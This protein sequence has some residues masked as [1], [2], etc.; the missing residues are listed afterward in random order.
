MIKSYYLGERT[1]KAEEILEIIKTKGKEKGYTTLPIQE[2]FYIDMVDLLNSDKNVSKLTCI[3]ARCGIGKSVLISAYTKWHADNNEGLIVVTDNLERLNS[4]YNFDEKSMTNIVKIEAETSILGEQAILNNKAVI[5]M[6]TQ[7]YFGLDKEQRE[8]LFNFKYG[9]LWKHRTKVI[10]DE[11]PSFY[12]ANEIG[13]KELNDIDTLL[14]DGLDETIN[15]KDEIISVFTEGKHRLLAYMET[16]ERKSDTDV[17]FFANLDEL[18]ELKQSFGYFFEKVE[19]YKSVLMKKDCNDAKNI[20]FLK[21]LLDEGGFFGGYKKTSG[22]KYSNSFFVYKNNADYFKTEN[23]KTKFFVF[24]ATS[25]IHPLYRQHFITLHNCTKY[26]IPL[27]LTIKIVNVSTS[28]NALNQEKV[29]GI[30]NYIKS[31][32]ESNEPLI[33]TY[34]EYEK[35]FTDISP[36]INHFGN[37]KGSNKHRQITE[38]FHIGVNRFNPFVYFLMAGTVVDDYYKDAI[39]MTP[40]RSIDFF[41]SILKT[42]SDKGRSKEA[43]VKYDMEQMLINSVIADF[44]QNIFRMSIRNIDNSAHNV[45]YL[46]INY[47][48]DTYGKVAKCIEE[49]FKGIATVEYLGTPDTIALDKLKNRNS[50]KGETNT[51]KV[52]SWIENLKVGEMFRTSDLLKGTKLTSKQLDK[53]KEHNECIRNSFLSMKTDKKG[54]YIKRA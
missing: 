49:R 39:S 44:E 3:P 36:N 34:K 9:R 47:E 13:V 14:R 33:F 30:A 17:L 4:I 19:K 53:V 15:D 5:L 40:E 8:I 10:F 51:Q 28:K 46:F 48:S 24:D 23:N 18:D 32:K 12:A 38:C 37:I 31:I 7:K 43:F 22:Y 1:P 16:L 35:Y 2:Q 54:Y 29:I 41:D 26:R 50:V 20:G 6:T 52:I 25:D 42:N 27:N 21:N 11:L 45:A